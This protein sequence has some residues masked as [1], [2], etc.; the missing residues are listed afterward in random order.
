[1]SDDISMLSD[2]DRPVLAKSGP[3]NQ[4]GNRH[5]TPNGKTKRRDASSSL[6]DDG[7]VPLVSRT[8]LLRALHRH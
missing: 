3:S 4:N 5:A 1:M 7:D 2:D 8:F 6:S